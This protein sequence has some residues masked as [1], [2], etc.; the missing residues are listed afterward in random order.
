MPATRH[1]R[2][3]SKT[4][5]VRAVGFAVCKRKF[6][7][8]YAGNSSKQTALP[9]RLSA[10]G[11]EVLSEIPCNFPGIREFNGGDLFAAASPHSHLVA[12]FPALY[13]TQTKCPKEARNCA[14][15]WQSFSLTGRQRASLAEERRAFSCLSL[16]GIF[17]GHTRPWADS[18]AA[19]VTEP[20]HV[21]SGPVSGRSSSPLPCPLMSHLGHHASAAFKKDG[22][23]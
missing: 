23:T 13:P 14:T 10:R 7:V 6:P 5:A 3:R 12:G 18:G 11:G 9:K 1:R 19:K 22:H 21:R 15:N 16:L 17:R 2:S 4:F 8:R 20:R